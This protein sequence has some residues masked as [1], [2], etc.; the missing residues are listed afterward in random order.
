MKNYLL[1][2]LLGLIAHISYSQERKTNDG[3]NT[4]KNIDR[5][6]QIPDTVIEIELKGKV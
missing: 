4:I 3:T 2:F 1:A 5:Y 6:A